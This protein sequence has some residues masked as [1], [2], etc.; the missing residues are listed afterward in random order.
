M[1]GHPHPLL[2]LRNVGQQQGIVAAILSAQRGDEHTREDPAAH[3]YVEGPVVRE[4]KVCGHAPGH[5]DRTGSSEP[6]PEVCVLHLQQ[7]GR[8]LCLSRIEIY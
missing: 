5:D 7:L 2:R 3:I 8:G 1:P 4:A 6:L